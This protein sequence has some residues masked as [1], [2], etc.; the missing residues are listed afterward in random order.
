MNVCE[1]IQSELTQL[2][3][4]LLDGCKMLACSEYLARHKRALMVTAVAWAKEHNLLDQNV[5]CYQKKW[6]R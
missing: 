5:K 2:L 6:N 3:Q 1:F 4:R